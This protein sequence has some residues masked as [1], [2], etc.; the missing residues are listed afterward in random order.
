MKFFVQSFYQYSMNEKKPL[1]IKML[2]K[3]N[4]TRLSQI[5]VK[6]FYQAREKEK[7]STLKLIVDENLIG[8]NIEDYLMFF[9][10]ESHK[11]AVKFINSNP[12]YKKLYLTLLEVRQ[13]KIKKEI[14]NKIKRGL[15]QKRKKIEREIKI[16]MEQK[17]IEERSIE[18]NQQ[19]KELEYGEYADR[20]REKEIEIQQIAI[21]EKETMKKRFFY[22]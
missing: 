10:E 2:T 17:T 13:K 3:F 4:H 7:L 1:L 6:F 20:E 14:K 11:H 21:E 9:E 5:L 19:K 15:E 12:A 16:A 18:R 22:N 8:S